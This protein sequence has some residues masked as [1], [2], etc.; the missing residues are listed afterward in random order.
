MPKRAAELRVIEL[1]R[2]SAKGRH[3]VGGVQGL[4]L[5]I[6]DTGAKSWILRVTVNGKRRHIGLGA[7]DE[8]GLAEARELA[9]EMRKKIA[10]GIDPIEERKEVRAAARVESQQGLTFAEAF[11]RYFSEKLESEL[12]N[13]KH[14]AQWRSTLTT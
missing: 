5:N 11:E 1:K 8:V 13:P 12:S 3:G 14:R 2:L 7:L 9:R 10:S 6:T 4:Y